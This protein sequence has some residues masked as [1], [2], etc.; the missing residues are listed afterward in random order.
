MRGTWTAA[1]VVLLRERWETW[2]VY[3]IASSLGRDKRAVWNK[4]ARLGLKPVP[5][6]TG[7]RPQWPGLADGIGLLD[8]EGYTNREIAARFGC[9]R[10]TVSRYRRRA[11]LPP[12]PSGLRSGQNRTLETRG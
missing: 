6:P 5:R 12:A 10:K 8:R 9:V 1:D 7:R 3:A 2:P 4:A 11:G